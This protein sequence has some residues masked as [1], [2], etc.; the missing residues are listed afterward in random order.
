MILFS[1]SM[2]IKYMF[3]GLVSITLNVQLVILFNIRLV[4]D[5]RLRLLLMKRSFFLYVVIAQTDNN[6]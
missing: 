4:F 5:F 1:V 2:P 3:F 6:L